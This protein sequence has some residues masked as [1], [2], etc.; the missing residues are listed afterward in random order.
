MSGVAEPLR[1]FV[2]A[3]VGEETTEALK[4]VMPEVEKAASAVRVGWTRPEG[5][6]LTL[7]FL[8]DVPGGSVEGIC[9]A[10]EE[11]V[12][13]Y[14][15]VEVE[16]PGLMTIPASRAP[17]IVAVALRDSS[18]SEGLSCLAEASTSALEPLGFAREH[19]SFLPHITLGR[20]RFDSR[21]R[22]R[23]A[24]V[25]VGAKEEVG[26]AA[27]A[28]AAS[29]DSRVAGG[30][31][32]SRAAAADLRPLCSFVASMAE[33]GFGRGVIETVSLY[34]S[35]LGAGGS[36]YTRIADFPLA[37]EAMMKPISK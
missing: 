25:E 14:S 24:A 13:V 15:P 10:L 28:A 22:P 7:S 21:R 16:A 6:H 12:G 1:C 4:E 35:E 27:G 26:A 33:H 9:R 20:V 36:R 32:A 3:T 34:R 37:G 29:R 11:G 19:N 5:W 2:A 23:S 31:R 8:G 18:G 17:R 30:R